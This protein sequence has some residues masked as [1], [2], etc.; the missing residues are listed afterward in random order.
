MPIGSITSNVS[1]AGISIQS[2]VSRQAEG[3]ESHEVVLPA[4]KSG[5]LSARTTDTT[6]DL[7]LSA[8][9]GITTGDVI[10]I[11]WDGGVQYG[12]TV[13]T[14]AG[15]VVPFSGGAGTVLPAQDTTVTASVQTE[16]DAD[17]DGDNMKMLAIHGTKRLHV[18]FQ[19]SGSVSLY[20]AEL[21][22]NEV[23]WWASDSGESNPLA[24]NPVDKVRASTGA[25][26][27]A[28]CKI[29]VL[30]DSTP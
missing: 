29:G 27:A 25:T 13:G 11:Y 19:D 28:T 2:T 1:I 5:S 8:G 16:I 10:D 18:D 7:T 14:V 15:N 4:A 22:A 20:A 12:A 17:F 26:E 6:G 9:H 21:A 24:G 23:D 30:F 3:Q